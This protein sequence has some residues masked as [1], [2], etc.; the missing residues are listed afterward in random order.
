MPQSYCGDETDPNK[1]SGT[2]DSVPGFKNTISQVG[3]SA[4][5]EPPKTSKSDV[6]THVSI[7]YI[8][9]AIPH[10]VRGNTVGDGFGGEGTHPF[11]ITR[12][13]K[14]PSDSALPT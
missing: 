9:A 12:L 1:D 10:M 4:N 7:H 3:S 6:H 13:V 2:S 11:Y 14:N 5:M 8:W